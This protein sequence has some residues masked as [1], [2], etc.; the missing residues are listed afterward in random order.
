MSA[1]VAP[2][3]PRRPQIRHPGPAVLGRDLSAGAASRSARI[4]EPPPD[5]CWPAGPVSPVTLQFAHQRLGEPVLRE[6]DLG[7]GADE[8]GC[9]AASG[10][11]RTVRAGRT[12][13]DARA[14]VRD[15]VAGQSVQMI[16]L[17]VGQAQ[18]AGQCPQHLRRRLRP[19]APAPASRSSP[20][21]IPVSCAT[22]SR[23]SPAVR[24]RTPAGNPTSAGLIASRRQA[25]EFAPARRDPSDHSPP[26]AGRLRQG[27]SI[28]ASTRPWSTGCRF[29]LDRLAPC[30]PRHSELLI[31]SGSR[32]RLHGHVG[33]LRRMPTAPRASAPCVPRSR[34][35]ITLLDTGDFYGDGAQ[36]TAARRG[37]AVHAR[38]TPTN[39]A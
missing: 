30:E 22:S 28:P 24:R 37:A 38:A 6:D 16:G 33:R 26:G 17:V 12:C 7:V 4:G 31:T 10:R 14:A 36:R 23:R 3:S 32:P 21:D 20:T 29:R 9:V 13:S 8:G 18:G 19:C 25:Q 39:S 34:R 11:G 35:A 1:S 27:L 2:P 15:G 5:S